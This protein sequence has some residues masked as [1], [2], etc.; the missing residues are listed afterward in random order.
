MQKGAPIKSSLPLVFGA[1]ILVSAL[2]LFS[3]QPLAGKLLLPLLGGAP[4]VW[5]TVMVFFQAMLLL[6]Y[7]Y[8]HWSFQWLGFKRQI[9]VHLALLILAALQLPFAITAAAGDHHP[10]L[11]VLLTLTAAIGLPVFALA[12]TAP[13]LQ[14]WFAC[15][16]HSSA[17]D[18]Y[19]L[20]AASN[21]GSFAALFAYPLALFLRRKLP[22]LAGP[23]SPI[24]YAR[25][26]DFTEPYTDFE[27]TGRLVILRP[28]KLG[29]WHSGIPHVYVAR[30]RPGVDFAAVGFVPGEVPLSSVVRLTDGVT[31]AG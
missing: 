16:S 3:V 6:G 18:P 9:I 22:R 31:T 24:V 13:L 15:S 5:N 2:L 28:R 26:A 30:A 19:F 29:V 10:A 8:A 21:V 14:K 27:R 12:A 20:Y 25:T 17:N 11:W 7:A 23:L 1:T 4:A